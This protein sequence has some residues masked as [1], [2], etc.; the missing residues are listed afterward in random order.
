LPAERVLVS[1]SETMNAEKGLG[2]RIHFVVGLVVLTAGYAGVLMGVK[3][4][5][6]NV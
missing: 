1:R 6:G 2:S 3:F 5:I 4:L